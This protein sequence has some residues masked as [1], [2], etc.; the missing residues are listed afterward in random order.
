MMLLLLLV[1]AFGAG[2][3]EGHY[4]DPGTGAATPLLYWYPT[5]AAEAVQRRG[6]ATLSIAVDAAPAAGRFPAVVLSHGSG[7]TMLGHHDTACELARH[8]YVVATPLH[9]GNNFDDHSAE[10]TVRLWRDRPRQVRAALDALLA[11]PLL[12]PHVD[13]RRLG[14]IGFSA[15][16]YSVLG[17]TGAVADPHRIAVHCRAHPDDRTFCGAAG[18]LVIPPGEPLVADPPD[19]RLRAA[20][21]MA[22][23]G[24]LFAEH[25][26]DRVTIPI[27]LYRAE[28]DQVLRQ[29]WHAERVRALLPRPPEYVVV[30]GAGHYAFLAPFPPS[31]VKVVGAPARDPPG[32]DRA[33]FHRR[34]DQEI[35]AFFDAHLR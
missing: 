31:L 5:V 21:V 19:A 9:A 3:R 15:G 35:R 2:L 18:K 8:G 20:V 27:R 24:A 1:G 29:P 32:F 6:P 14:A 25:S 34:L 33:A 17:A 30:L 26:L 16:G 11:D 13:E 28:K 22:P 7:G 23:V 10:G 4:R 12:A